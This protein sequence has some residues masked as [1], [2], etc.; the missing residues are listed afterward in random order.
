MMKAWQFTNTHEPLVLADIA[1]PMPGPGEVVLDVHAAGLCHSDVGV[2]TDPAW[3]SVLP[4]H[5]IVIGHEIAGVARELGPGVQG[6]ELGG[7][8][9]V[10]PMG[11]HGTP[12]F[13]RDGGF[14]FRHRVAAEDLVAV[15]DGLALELAA[16]GTDAGMTAHHAVMTQGAVRAAERVGIIGLGGLGQIGARLAVLAGAEVHVADPNESTW[17]LAAELGAA[18]AVAQATEWAG[19]DFDV[20]VDFA[21]YGTTTAAAVEAIRRDGRVVVVGMGTSTMTLETMRVVRQQARIIGANGGSKA[22]IAAVYALMSAGEL[23]PTYTVIDFDG[24]PGGLDDLRHHR[25]TGRLV[26][27]L[28]A[29]D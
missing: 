29:R 26:A 3:A 8:Y 28:E 5:P 9:G 1:E 14:T 18:G 20:V 21:G 4:D 17:V 12:G 2:L 23:R 15:P 11:A 22:D 19:R 7:R 16:M 13:A 10:W 25:V 6:V 27:R 24:I